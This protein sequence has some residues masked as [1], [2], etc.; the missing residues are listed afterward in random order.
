MDG[1][2]SKLLENP[3]I[4][5]GLYWSRKRFAPNDTVIQEGEEGKEVYVVISGTL[6]VFSK[7]QLEDHREIQPGFYE[8]N[9][10]ELFGELGLFDSK[11]SASVVAVT[12]C[13]LAAFDGEKLLDF[14]DSHPDIGYPVLKE[15]VSV[16][17]ERLRNTNKKVFSLFAWALK[18]H[19]ISEHL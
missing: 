5:E 16:L 17:I 1:A 12:D 6:R 8:L 11:R 3:E 2:L 9:E 18:A 19:G 4:T 10:G 15:I 14:F 13:E 7:L